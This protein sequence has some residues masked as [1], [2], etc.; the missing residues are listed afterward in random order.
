MMA[1]REQSAETEM[2]SFFRMDSGPRQICVILPDAVSTF[3]IP[4]SPSK[5]PAKRIL[6]AFCQVSQLGDAAIAGVTFRGL[7]PWA[8]TTKMSPPVE[9]SS[10]MSPAMRAMFF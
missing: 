7:P 3:A 5:R 4:E 2:D 1:D 9:P 6:L 8:G 10:L